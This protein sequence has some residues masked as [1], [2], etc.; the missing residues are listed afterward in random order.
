M[1][2]E[3]T[4][5]KIIDKIS[6]I[7]SDY[8]ILEMLDEEILNWDYGYD[9][10]EIDEYDSRYDFYANYNNNEAEDAVVDELLQSVSHYFG[11]IKLN[12]NYLFNMG[13]G[14]G[15]CLTKFLDW[16]EEY[17]NHNFNG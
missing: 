14:Y 12:R 4:V 13:E 8:D 10:D 11:V 5:E 6:S 16:L 7:Y 15:A 3:L 9:Q 17:T 1:S 2:L